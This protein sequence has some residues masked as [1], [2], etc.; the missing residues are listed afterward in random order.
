MQGVR[1]RFE[2]DMVHNGK[3]IAAGQFFN[4]PWAQSMGCL[5]ILWRYDT[6]QS[7]PAKRIFRVR[8]PVVP[9]SQRLTTPGRWVWV[10][11]KWAATASYG[12]ELT[13]NGSD[14][15]LA[16]SAACNSVVCDYVGSIPTAATLGYSYN[17][18]YLCLPSI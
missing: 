16:K 18:Y 4:K 3:G 11:R 17:G 13:R 5:A 6:V 10:D 7:T 1:C 15:K 2:S 8:L 14:G 12:W 9:L